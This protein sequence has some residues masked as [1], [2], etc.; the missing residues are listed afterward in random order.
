MFSLLNAH[1]ARSRARLSVAALGIRPGTAN[2]DTRVVAAALRR[3]GLPARN[4]IVLV[5]VLTTAGLT[6]AH[7]RARLA[8]AAAVLAWASV[9]SATP[10][11]RIAALIASTA[12]SGRLTMTALHAWQE[13]GVPAVPAL[14][15]ALEVDR[16]DLAYTVAAG[17]VSFLV[18]LEALFEKASVQIGG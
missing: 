11:D 18:F 7:N 16:I 1:R 13:A 17:R 3:M 6:T 5:P 8:K 12:A 14:L 2:A 4:A 15:K 9:Y 10:P